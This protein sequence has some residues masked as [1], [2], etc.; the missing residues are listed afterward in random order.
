M[1]STSAARRTRMT[2]S[3]AGNRLDRR[4]PDRPP[5][6]V[7]RAGR[8]LL[9]IVYALAMAACVKTP[10]ASQV[11]GTDCESRY[12]ISVRAAR[13]GMALAVAIGLA[14]FVVWFAVDVA[15]RGR[16]RQHQGGALLS[17]ASLT[18]VLAV[19]WL[20]VQTAGAYPQ[21]RLY[22]VAVATLAWLP[23]AAAVAGIAWIVIGRWGETINQGQIRWGAFH[24]T[25]GVV[26]W[27]VLGYSVLR[28][29]DYC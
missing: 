10:T 26:L 28:L 18:G 12:P 19:A 15:T 6:R 21:G 9:P 29:S 27:P 11:A 2:S 17:A 20:V 8:W 23:L 24:L 13:D 14:L 4:P 1:S 3:E 5:G 7:T 25:A 16:G 22:D